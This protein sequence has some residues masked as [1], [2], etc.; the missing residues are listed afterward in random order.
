MFTSLLSLF[1]IN[2]SFYTETELKFCIS[3]CFQ[4]Q[5]SQE[6]LKTYK[7]DKLFITY[8]PRYYDNTNIICVFCM[9]VSACIY[10][11]DTQWRIQ[12]G[13]GRGSGV[14]CTHQTRNV[15]SILMTECTDPIL[16][17]LFIFRTTRGKAST[18]FKVSAGLKNLG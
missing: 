3:C 9:R 2:L 15:W 1:Y 17:T 5:P 18:R 16:A 11:L 6:Y 8:A 13:E 7:V 10:V 4:M 12:G 14:Q